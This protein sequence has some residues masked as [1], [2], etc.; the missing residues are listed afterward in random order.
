MSLFHQVKEASVT[1]SNGK[2]QSYETAE[3]EVKT[4][5]NSEQ[6]LAAA[7]DTI[8]QTPTASVTEEETEDK[9]DRHSEEYRHLPEKLEVAISSISSNTS[10]EPI[11]GDATK[12]E[13]CPTD[14]ETS[15]TVPADSTSSPEE[16]PSESENNP[17]VDGSALSETGTGTPEDSGN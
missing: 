2:S 4:N 7:E 13:D 6:N 16:V 12:S 9:S 14:A 8:Q 5:G 17:S 1:H 3:V 10:K 11:A 15:V